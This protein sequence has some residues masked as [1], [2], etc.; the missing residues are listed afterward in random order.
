MNEMMKNDL[1]DAIQD[2]MDFYPNEYE[3]RHREYEIYRSEFPKN[4]SDA[5]I[6][7]LLERDRA[8]R[9]PSGLVPC[10]DCVKA[11]TMNCPMK[12]QYLHEDGYCSEG[13]K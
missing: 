1:I 12:L 9:L 8:K 10:K 4:M 7:V 5:D 11:Q 2:V 13:V 6:I 3:D